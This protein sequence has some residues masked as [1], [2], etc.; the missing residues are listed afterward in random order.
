MWIANQST[1]ERIARRSQGGLLLLC[2]FVLACTKDTSVQV[3]DTPTREEA[4]RPRPAPAK[5][6]APPRRIGVSS[7]N[8]CVLS[9]G[10][11]LCWGAGHNKRGRRGFRMVNGKKEYKKGTDHSWGLLPSEDSANVDA[12]AAVMLEGVVDARLLEMDDRLACAASASALHC[13]YASQGRRQPATTWDLPGPLADLAVG[14]FGTD[15][16]S[17]FVVT[18]D[19]QLHQ[20]QDDSWQ[21]LPT[22]HAAA[23]ISVS[24]RL[25]MIDQ[26]G[27][28][29]SK[30]HDSPDWRA[31]G[32]RGASQVRSHRDTACFAMESSS[33]VHCLEGDKLTDI[34]FPSKLESMD[35]GAGIVC[36]VVEGG[37][38]Y[39]S[40]GNGYLFPDAHYPIANPSRPVAI[41]FGVKAT[42]VV[43]AN[44]HGCALTA[45]DSLRCWGIGP[46]KQ[47]GYASPPADSRSPATSG[48][49]PFGRP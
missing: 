41:D 14:Q 18:T 20:R 16:Q 49:V 25:F 26:N 37:G 33:R 8:T 1:S 22:P 7:A 48:D 11:V 45:E 21:V 24:G 15:W 30:E 17:V 39:C 42:T 9:E 34:T 10:R 35:V 5:A 3:D 23:A 6:P 12:T 29:W 38:L 40:G 2:F 4:A 27:E 44:V 19:G 36:A 43:V 47:L 31:L 46:A 13:W 28:A 32:I